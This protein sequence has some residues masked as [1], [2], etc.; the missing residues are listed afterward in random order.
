MKKSILTLAVL[1]SLMT[2]CSDDAQYDNNNQDTAT[3]PRAATQD[4]INRVLA[5]DG[6]VVSQKAFAV[7]SDKFIDGVTNVKHSSDTTF[8][9]IHNDLLAKLKM[10][11]LKTGDVIDV[12][13]S[14]ENLPYVRVVDE[15]TKLDNGMTRCTTHAGDISDLFYAMDMKFNT[16]L[17]SDPSKRSATTR[18]GGASDTEMLSSENAEQFREGKVLHPAVIYSY[19]ENSN[20]L[21]YQLSEK[22]VD[23]QT[24]LG[25]RKTIVEKS[26][27]INK[28]YKVC[29]GKLEYGVRN[30]KLDARLDA[31]VYI[32]IVTDLRWDF[33]NMRP[34]VQQFTTRFIGNADLNLPLYIKGDTEYKWSKSETIA[35][36]PSCH[37]VFWVGG[38]PVEITIGQSIEFDANLQL[39][40]GFDAELPVQ[41][42]LNMSAGPSYVDGNWGPAFDFKPNY[43][44]GFDKMK[45]KADGEVKADAAIYYK[46]AARFYTVAGPSLAV[47]PKVNAEASAHIKTEGANIKT[48]IATKGKVSVAGKVGAEVK[49]LKWDLGKFE[50]PFTLYEK[51]LWN[52]SAT[53][54]G[55]FINGDFKTQF[56]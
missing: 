37:K 29:D 22:L 31:E 24:R 4:S 10:D 7:T 32:N 17:Y 47:G 42:S 52:K 5:E 20:K 16:T 1:A 6:F 18:S 3:D 15:V 50:T 12:W 23:E 56:K 43:S 38:F 11:S 51:E 13:E 55:N 36:L 34:R 53:V 49:F 46:V 26:F 54:E 25:G 9:D 19:D 48:E 39:K 30:G 40:A 33:W 28:N 8:V 44:V 35:E 45:L 2:A 21:T 27:D 41:A 14:V